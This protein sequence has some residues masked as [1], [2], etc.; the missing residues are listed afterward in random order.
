MIH[1]SVTGVPAEMQVSFAAANFSCHNVTKHVAYGLAA[2]ALNSTASAVGFAF[3]DAGQTSPLCTFTAK[4]VGLQQDT[5]YYYAVDG[6]AVFSFRNQPSHRAGGRVYAVL[7][8]MGLDN[9]QAAAQIV[10]E[11]QADEWDAIIY[12]GDFAYECVVVV[13]E[14]VGE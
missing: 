11:A 7:G 12:S 4:L 3:Q 1:L 6:G 10:A 5:V 2:S 14:W 9:D 13:S 8:D